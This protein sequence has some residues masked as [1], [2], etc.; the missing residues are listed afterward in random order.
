MQR[1][2]GR[3]SGRDGSSVLAGQNGE[4]CGGGGCTSSIEKSVV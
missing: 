3:G 4:E 1:G 2:T